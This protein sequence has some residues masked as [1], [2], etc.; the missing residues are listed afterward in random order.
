MEEENEIEVRSDEVQEILSSMPSWMIRRGITLIF[1]IILL[2]LGLSYLIKYP[3]VIKGTVVLTTKTP[4]AK[5]VTK[6]SGD[7]DRL[8]VADNH[9]VKTGDLIAQIRNPL[10]KDAVAYLKDKAEE[11]EKGLATEFAKKIEFEEGAMVFGNVQNDYNALVQTISEYRFSLSDTQYGQR[12]K[13]LQR[14]IRNYQNLGEINNRQLSYSEQNFT[15]AVEKYESNK[16]LYEKGVISKVAFYEQE[17]AYT[18]AKNEI[19]NLKKNKVQNTITL[20]DYERQ[21]NEMEIEYLSK[22]LTLTKSIET[23]LNNI[24]NQIN[25]WQETY[26]ITATLDGRLNY[27]TQLS[28]NQFVEAG[29]AL[30]AI[31]PEQEDEFVGYVE[32]DKRGYGKIKVGQDVKMQF[33]NF[34]SAEYGQIKGV[35]K[36]IAALPNEE[37]YLVQIGLTDGLMSTYKKKLTYSPEMSGQADI[38]T[39]DLRI[40]ERIFNQFRKL[41]DE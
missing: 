8:F 1:V 22:K 30:F 19:E 3:D 9:L 23:H 13:I 25:N 10:S 5:L 15:L 32:V 27:I 28:E 4:P 34:P 2:C 37:K 21:L 38:V 39:E 17:M 18:Q 29:K 16:N 11:V 12:K 41:F 36:N 33:D 14:Q 35:V 24:R 7:I 20:T 40:L 31:I 26:L 6:T